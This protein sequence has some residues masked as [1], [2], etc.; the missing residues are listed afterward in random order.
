MQIEEFCK[1]YNLGQV[2]SITKLIGGLMHKM[3]KVE[4]DKKNYA[5]KVLNPEVMKRSTALENFMISETISNLA[6]EQGIPV[7]CAIKIDDTF[8]PK[9]KDTYYMVFDFIEGNTLKDEQITVNHC[10]EIGQILSS[11][12]NLDYNELGLN[13]EIKEDHFYVDWELF[14]NNTNFDNMSYKDLYLNN[15]KKYYSI[16]KRSVER[17]NE[18]NTY[19]TICHADMDP[20]NV[21]WRNDEPIII[22]WESATLK[23][24]YREL[25][26]DALCWSGFLSNNFDSNKFSAVIEEYLKY[27][28]IETDIYSVICGNLVGRFGWLDYNLKRS[29]GI[30]SNDREE[31]LL[32]ENEVTKTINE[33]NRYLELIGDIYKIANNL[34]NPSTNTTNQYIEKLI[35]NNELLKGKKY[36]KINAGFT[37]TIYQV[38]NY[39]VR[40]CTDENN[41]NNFKNEIDFYSKYQNNNIPKLYFSDTSK[42]TIPYYYDIIERVE[43]HTLYE[44]WYKI[45]SSKRIEIVK[46]IINI[47]KNIHSINVEETDFRNYIKD[48]LSNFIK[49][50]S[51]NNS[52]LNK[53]IAKCDIYF[54]E[55]KFG[56]IHN[57]L[58]FDNFIFDGHKITLI[59]FERCINGPIDYDFRIFNR[60]NEEPWKW[61]S[62][63]TDM[64]TVEEDYQNLIDLFITNYDE[65]RNIPYLKERLNIY[66][67]IDYLDDYKRTNNNEILSKIIKLTEDTLEK[68]ID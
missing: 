20:K 11:I 68:T 18:S 23:N 4:T 39:I 56:L 53:L 7:S 67:I 46:E 13:E 10:R 51:I 42:K 35:V 48:S 26:E 22:D 3:F 34:I 55:N 25:I 58:H 44:I 30:K 15:Y 40:I 38:D 61:A 2:K 1:F 65:L 31:M 16:L 66:K 63:K 14:I 21:M 12:H 5:I 19:L 57:D 60:Y 49:E 47:L 59:D 17:F 28:K 9:Y 27:N 52:S 24:P 6:K 8:I 29:L 37:N 50:T 62:A 32:A 33:I 64:L 41:E 54:K 36:T 43:G 45:S